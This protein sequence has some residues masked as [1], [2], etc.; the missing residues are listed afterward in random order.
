MVHDLRGS[1]WAE[2]SRP[3][4]GR[5]SRLE[6]I[7]ACQAVVHR[8]GSGRWMQRE[9]RWH[10]DAEGDG[11]ED[12]LMGAAGEFRHLHCDCL[13]KSGSNCTGIL[14]IRRCTHSLT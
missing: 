11:D 5:C 1:G 14:Q 8:P 12:Y 7:L 9:R 6:G 2:R 10:E 4:R 3:G 13:H